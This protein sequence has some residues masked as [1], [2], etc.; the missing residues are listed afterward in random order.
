M[1]SLLSYACRRIEASGDG[2]LLEHE[3]SQALR[4]AASKSLNLMVKRQHKRHQREAALDQQL[5]GA[6]PSVASM[7]GKKAYIACCMDP[8]LLV[9]NGYFLINTT[10]LIAADVIFAADPAGMRAKD[11]HLWA[12]VLL[13]SFIF[14]PGILSGSGE[15]HGIRYRPALRSRRRVYLSDGFAA[16]SPRLFAFLLRCLGS[17]T[18]NWTRIGTAGEFLRLKNGTH[19]SR[20]E[21][22]GTVTREELRHAPFAGVNHTFHPARLLTFLQHADWAHTSTCAACDQHCAVDD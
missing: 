8:A 2:L 3:D 9:S 20:S 4:N 16:R 6:L 11:I 21:V 10:D 22:I 13:G 14:S 5:R 15:M 7:R 17:P 1:A 12:G 18:S 19:K